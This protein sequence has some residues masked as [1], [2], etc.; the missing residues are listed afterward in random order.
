M[1]GE[2][3]FVPAEL[4]IFQRE[5]W[6]APIIG[7][8]LAGWLYNSFFAESRNEYNLEQAEIETAQEV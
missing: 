2:E 5:I 4:R 8:L 1:S 3:Q 7:A 6:V